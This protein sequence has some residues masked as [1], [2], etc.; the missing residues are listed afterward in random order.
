MPLCPLLLAS[1]PWDPAI[2]LPVQLGTE[3]GTV[4]LSNVLKLQLASVQQYSHPEKQLNLFLFFPTA[5]G[6]FL[7]SQSICSL[8]F[9]MAPLS[10]Q[11][12]PL[13]YVA[14]AS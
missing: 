9:G 10:P 5:L 14:L 1:W 3:S 12:L 8:C 2:S 13:I 7:T 4:A 11:T 6:S